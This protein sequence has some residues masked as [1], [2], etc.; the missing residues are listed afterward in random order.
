MSGGPPRVGFPVQV[1]GRP[2]LKSHD[3]RRWQSGPHLRVSLDRLRRIFAYLDARGVRMHRMASGLV[4][5]AAH[6]DHPQSRGQVEA[7]ATELGGLGVLARG[8]GLRLSFHPGQYVA[9]HAPD[10]QLAARPAADVE[11]QGR[12]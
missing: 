10:D 1:L 4:P 5:Y 12:P 11:V 2:G 7:C 8:T 6:P 9:L 3:S